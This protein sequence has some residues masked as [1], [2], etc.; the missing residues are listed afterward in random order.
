MMLVT[1]G[2]IAEYIFSLAGSLLDKLAGKKYKTIPENVEILLKIT[3]IHWIRV[4]TVCHVWL[5]LLCFLIILFCE[6]VERCTKPEKI[7]EWVYL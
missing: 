5:C 6:D 1:L 3:S 7:V 4:A 2:G